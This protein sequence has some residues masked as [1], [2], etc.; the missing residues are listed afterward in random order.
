[1]VK[2]IIVCD[3]CG[4]ESDKDGRFVLTTGRSM[5]GAG[6]MEDDVEIVDLCKVCRARALEGFIKKLTHQDSR[7]FVLK[8]KVK[9]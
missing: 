2:T 6:D 7:A 9:R 1:M 5:T 3:H 4:A 8:W